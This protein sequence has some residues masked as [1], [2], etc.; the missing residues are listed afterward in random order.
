MIGFHHGYLSRPP[1]TIATYGDEPHSSAA[2]RVP[3]VS[4]GDVMAGRI[5]GYA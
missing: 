1:G 5:A 4:G 2:C 3:G